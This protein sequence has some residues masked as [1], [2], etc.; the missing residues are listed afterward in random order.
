MSRYCLRII[1]FCFNTVIITVLHLLHRYMNTY[2]IITSSPFIALLPLFHHYHVLFVCHHHDH[3]YHLTS[4]FCPS[5]SISVQ[6]T[7]PN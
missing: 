7:A 3:H 5:P 6:Y 2:V 4:F 1:V